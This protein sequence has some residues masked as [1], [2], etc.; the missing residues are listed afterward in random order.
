LSFEFWV[1]YSQRLFS[2]VALCTVDYVRSKITTILTDS[3]IKDIIDETSSDILTQCETTVETNTL[4]I[5]AGKYAIIAA[6]LSKM[7]TTG[8][9][10]ASIKTGNSQRQNT[11]DID[12]ERYEKK[13]QSFISQYLEVNSHTF[14]SP[15]FNAGFTHHHHGGHNG[16]N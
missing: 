8:E 13:S 2:D 15:S 6:T 1:I 11:T 16:F 14:S 3:D 10:A 12:I 4:I 7:K 9:M 5:L